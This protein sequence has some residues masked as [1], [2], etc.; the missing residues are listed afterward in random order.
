MRRRE[1]VG[2]V[3]IVSISRGSY[4]LGQEVAEKVAERLGYSCLARD[5]LL[6][7]SEEFNIPEIKFLRTLESAPSFFDRFRG[8]KERYIVFIRAALLSHLLEDNVVYHGLAG[9]FF[10]KGVGH[11]LKVRIVADLPDRLAIVMERDGVSEKKARQV[12]EASDE[13][14]R[15]WGLGLYGIDPE[16]P[17]LYDAVIHVTKMGADSAADMICDLVSHDPFR[18]TPES[19]SALEDLALAASA[20]AL[21]VEMEFA[22]ADFEVTVHLGYVHVRLKTVPRVRSGSDQSFHGY[23]LESLE[24]RLRARHRGHQRFR[25]VEVEL[26]DE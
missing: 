11:A 6:S 24:E 2:G 17:S 3:A 25:A 9:H 12:I 10:L 1:R 14:R 4:S 26:A 21:L 23:Y 7:A 20:E 18:T 13:V 15:Q 22:P 5:V 16:N 19:Q 8:G